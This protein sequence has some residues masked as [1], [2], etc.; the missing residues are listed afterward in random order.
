M[1][2]PREVR[3]FTGP[4]LVGALVLAVVLLPVL[5]VV[6]VIVSVWLPGRWRALRLLCFALVYLALQVVGLVVAVMM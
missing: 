2:P 6:A 3:R 1:L 5:V 4:L